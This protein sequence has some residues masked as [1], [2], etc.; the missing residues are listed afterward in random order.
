M[1]KKLLVLPRLIDSTAAK[2][3][4]QQRL[5]Y[6]D[7]THLVLASGKLVL[8]K[9]D[10]YGL[11]KIQNYH[12]SS[13]NSKSWESLW[14]KELGEELNAVIFLLRMDQVGCRA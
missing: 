11:G 1:M 14:E 7:R 5:N 4:G 13:F 10:Y 8:H 6:V 12:C 2:S 3:S 9:K